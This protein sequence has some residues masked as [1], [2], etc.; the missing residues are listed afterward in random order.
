N[1]E[2]IKNAAPIGIIGIDKDIIQCRIF[3]GT[4]TL[5]NILLKREF[6]VNITWNP[7]YFTLATIGKIDEKYFSKDG[8][9]LKG[10]DA[11]LKCEVIGDIKIQIKENDPVKKS[12]AG[13]FKSKVKE[14]V[15]NNPCVKAPNR[16]FYNLIEA[17]VNYTR[18][19]LV[20]KEKKEF[21]INRLNELNRVINKVGS[22]EEKK[23][24]KLVDDAYNSKISKN[25][26]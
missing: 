24:I 22:E 19:D 1:N 18:M 16:G 6:I 3:K 9:N 10:V 12:E 21:F 13:F 23:A 7:L 11:Y 2:N 5:E 8:L 15:I 25:E 20:D 4:T 17:L 26:K 14:I